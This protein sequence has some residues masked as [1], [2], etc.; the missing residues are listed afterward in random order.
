MNVSYDLDC[1]SPPTKTLS[2]EF[3]LD[4]YASSFILINFFSR[5]GIDFSNV[6]EF[7]NHQLDSFESDCVYDSVFRSDVT[8]T[9]LSLQ[10]PSC[11]TLERKKGKML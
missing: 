2:L 1:F 10:K 9:H 11:R 4:S 3:P 7:L 5:K 8:R 6:M